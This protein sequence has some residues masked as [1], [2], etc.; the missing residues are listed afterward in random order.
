MSEIAIQM[1]YIIKLDYYII[2]VGIF[3]VLCVST[4]KPQIPVLKVDKAGEGKFFIS[5]IN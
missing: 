1:M 3:S 2:K 5:K 4:A